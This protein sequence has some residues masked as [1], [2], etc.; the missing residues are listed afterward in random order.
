[1]RLITD[2]WNRLPS[3]RRLWPL[4]ALAVFITGL[5]SWQGV[6]AALEGRWLYVLF[7]VPGAIAW[8]SAWY[9]AYEVYRHRGADYGSDRNTVARTNDGIAFRQ[10]RRIHVLT[11]VSIFTIV[12]ACAVFAVGTWTDRLSF[13]MSRSQ[14]AVFGVLAAILAV[15]YTV[16]G[17]WFLLGW[18]RF[19]TVECTPTAIRSRRF[20][21][22][23]QISWDEVVGVSAVA[24]SKNASIHLLTSENDVPHHWFGPALPRA[25]SGPF[26]CPADLLGVGTIRLLEFLDHYSIDPDARSELA[27]GRAIDRALT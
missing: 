15:W 24:D 23:Q 1:M 25:K 21:S 20:L 19:P 22:S 18:A 27:D 2:A 6:V 5:W 3:R 11:A 17:I 9:P 10:S 12:L 8:L 7:Y 14:E 4:T 26:I 13:P 16:T